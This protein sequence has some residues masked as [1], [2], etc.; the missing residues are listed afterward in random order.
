MRTTIALVLVL[1]AAQEAPRPA[2]VDDLLDLVH[3]QAR[4]DETC[5]R[6]GSQVT[7][8][9]HERTWQVHA[10][11]KDG[12]YLETV[13]PE[14][15]PDHDGV[16]IRI[17]IR[18]KPYGGQLGLPQHVP[19]PYFGTFCSE[20]AE[21]GRYLYVR[22]AFGGAFPADLRQR[23]LE[24]LGAAS[25]MPAAI[26]VY[27]V[28]SRAEASYAQGGPIGVRVQLQNG[29]KHAI[30]FTT[31]GTEPAAS[32]AETTNVDLV[33]ICRDATPRNLYLARPELAIPATVAGPASHELEPGG[34][35]NVRID[36]AK[37]TI[38]GGWVPGTYE[39]T[40]RLNGIT[41]GGRVT[42]AVLSYPVR[43]VVE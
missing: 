39:V 38:D 36:L 24:R 13:R 31:F 41:V 19:G 33:D 4:G 30:R 2:L 37:W 42:L 6:Q 26:P 7:I 10:R 40:V 11:E 35:L 23:I 15:G 8:A 14:V 21:A 29:L 34:F 28:A 16:L 25:A 43:V 17:S 9:F 20:V 18:D 22:A 32:N 3:E 27:V 5:T 1:A 12:R